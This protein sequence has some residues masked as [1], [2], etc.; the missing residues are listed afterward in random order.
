MIGP[1]PK[2]HPLAEAP[3]HTLQQIRVKIGKW[4]GVADA[5]TWYI[6]ERKRI[7]DKCARDPYGIAR[8]ETLQA[9][10]IYR[11]GQ[12]KWGGEAAA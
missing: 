1:Q 3:R 7:L 4:Y 5:D 11:Q 9:F 10:W 2:I 12:T 6:L 8:F